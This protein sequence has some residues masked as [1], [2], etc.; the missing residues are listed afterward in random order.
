MVVPPIPDPRWIRRQE[1]YNVKPATYNGPT[2][3]SVDSDEDEEGMQIDPFNE[4][5]IRVCADP[6]DNSNEATN[7]NEDSLGE[8]ASDMVD[9]SSDTEK[10]ELIE[11]V[12][13]VKIEDED[14]IQKNGK[15]EKKGPPL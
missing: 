11:K 9:I 10:K 4:N 12:K 3:E 8:F 1:K 14:E 5:G 7:A 6:F 13:N 15:E 2:A